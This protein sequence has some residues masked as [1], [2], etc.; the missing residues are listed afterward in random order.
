MARR[1]VVQN[2]ELRVADPFVEGQSLKVVRVDVSVFGSPVGSFVFGYAHQPRSDSGAAFL[3]GDPEMADEE[4][5]PVGVADESSDQLIALMRKHDELP[6]LLRR[7]DCE[8]PGNEPIDNDLPIFRTRI[9]DHFELHLESLQA[10]TRS[11]L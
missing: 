6:V 5:V 3:I 9:L 11:R 8:I 1:V 10:T 4:P 7:S 2:A